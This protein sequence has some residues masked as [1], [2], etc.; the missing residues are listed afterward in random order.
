M[1]LF[2]FFHWITDLLSQGVLNRSEREQQATAVAAFIQMLD[3]EVSFRETSKVTR[4]KKTN[5]ECL[6]LPPLHLHP[7]WTIGGQT[8]PCIHGWILRTGK[9]IV[10]S[11]PANWNE[12]CG[13]VGNIDTQCS[14]SGEYYLQ[15]KLLAKLSLCHCSLE[16]K[17][18]WC[19]IW[20]SLEKKIPFEPLKC[21]KARV[22]L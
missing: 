7:S 8:M 15:L 19:G 2:S 3:L 14:C 9:G 21:L 20:V 5:F 12:E 22:L 11:E 16:Q 18:E 6:P 4:T 10:S 1:S 13:G 17:G